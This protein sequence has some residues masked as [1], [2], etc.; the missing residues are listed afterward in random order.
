MRHRKHPPLVL[1]ERTIYG[2]AYRYTRVVGGQGK[3]IV[4]TEP[5]PVGA[6]PEALSRLDVETFRTEPEKLS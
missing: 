4:E 6:Q 5:M 1:I 3:E 2:A